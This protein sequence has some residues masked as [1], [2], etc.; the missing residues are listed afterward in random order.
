MT[1][2]ASSIGHWNAFWAFNL[3]GWGF[4]V[5]LIFFFIGAPS[6]K[7]SKLDTYAA[8]EIVGEDVPYNY[9]YYF[10]RPIEM[11]FIPYFK[12]SAHK[13]YETISRFLVK[14]SGNIRLWYSGNL[15]SYVL[16]FIVFMFLVLIFSKLTI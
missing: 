5:G 15:Q 16:Y 9:S 2:V 1:Q 6:R 3:L 4:L 12:L 7:I 14:R 8:G 13:I 10:Y 11:V